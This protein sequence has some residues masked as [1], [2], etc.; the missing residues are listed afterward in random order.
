MSIYDFH[1]IDQDY[2][3]K[4]VGRALAIHLTPPDFRFNEETASSKL[5]GESGVFSP[6]LGPGRGANKRCRIIPRVNIRSAA[7][8]TEN[9]QWIQWTVS[10]GKGCH[11][12][13]T[14][15]SHELQTSSL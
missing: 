10:K 5:R 9:N 7:L 11:T 4:M 12:R 6:H 13:Y 3:S 2:V 1:G 15:W 8:P 14:A